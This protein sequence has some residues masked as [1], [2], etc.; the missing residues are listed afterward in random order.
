M[1]DMINAG[2]NFQA[3]ADDTPPQGVFIRT[4]HWEEIRMLSWALCR[5]LYP[6]V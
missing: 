5:T 1:M 2:D 4:P 3:V 6:R